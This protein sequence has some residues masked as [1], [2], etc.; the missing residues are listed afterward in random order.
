MRFDHFGTS[1]AIDPR[2]AWVEEG[3]P[4]AEASNPQQDVRPLPPDPFVLDPG[5]NPMRLPCRRD[6]GCQVHDGLTARHRGSD[7]SF[8]EERSNDRRCAV[9]GSDRGR[10]CTLDQ[11]NDLMTLSHQLA[12]R[13]RSEEHTSELQSLMRISYAVFCL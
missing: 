8:V 5:R 9:E 12:N 4:A 10:L 11:S 13:G 3:L 7:A 6:A 1:N 2:D